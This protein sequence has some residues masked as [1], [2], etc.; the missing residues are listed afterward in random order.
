MFRKNNY[1]I[2][3][4]YTEFYYTI[5]TLKAFSKFLFFLKNRYAKIDIKMI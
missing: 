5:N 4:C 3:Y 2:I 1:F